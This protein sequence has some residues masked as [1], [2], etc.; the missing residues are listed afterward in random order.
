MRQPG[1]ISGSK[2]G[3]SESQDVLR[4]WAGTLLGLGVL[5]AVP[6]RVKDQGWT[7][8]FPKLG[9]PSWGPCYERILLLGDLSWGVSYF[10]KPT[11]NVGLIPS[12]ERS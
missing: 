5:K 11:C 10:C 3:Q 7:W 4:V 2:R 12:Q 1:Q 9:V 8:G 6:F